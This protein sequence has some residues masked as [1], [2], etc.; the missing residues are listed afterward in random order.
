MVPKSS[1]FGME[2]DIKPL[3]DTSEADGGRS[4]GE[5]A[6]RTIR[7]RARGKKIKLDPAR[8]WVMAVGDTPNGDEREGENE[9]TKEEQM[10][11]G[12]A[13]NETES[14][15]ETKRDKE[16]ERGTEKRVETPHGTNWGAY[17]K[18]PPSVNQAGSAEWLVGEV[19]EVAGREGERIT[20]GEETLGGEKDT[21]KTDKTETLA[22]TDKTDKTETL[23]ET[24]KTESPD[25][26]EK[27]LEVHVKKD[28]MSE[29]RRSG[30]GLRFLCFGGVKKQTEKKNARDTDGRGS[31]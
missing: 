23:A 8:K 21:D 7:K 26:T 17:E 2:R 19:R 14:E 3:G 10:A 13:A 25:K 18:P 30:G 31:N 22:E 1:S 6:E 4:E 12:E 20:E 9:E 24:D 11:K 27:W 15:R 29:K 28:I 16:T 5:D